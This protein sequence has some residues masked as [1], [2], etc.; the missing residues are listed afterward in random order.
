LKRTDKLGERGI[1][2]NLQMWAPTTKYKGKNKRGGLKRNLWTSSWAN[3]GKSLR[4]KEL[5]VKKN[6]LIKMGKKKNLK[7]IRTNY[8]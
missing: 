8:W 7:E 3:V 4:M 1:K 2:A 6:A 5:G